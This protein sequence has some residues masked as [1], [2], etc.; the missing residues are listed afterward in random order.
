MNIS[1]ARQAKLD[2]N[3]R[4]NRACTGS[5]GDCVDR[6][7]ADVHVELTNGQKVSLRLCMSHAIQTTQRGLRNG[8]AYAVTRL[9][10]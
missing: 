8:I 4:I 6:A 5:G 10:D 1:E 2:A 7:I 9:D 3:A